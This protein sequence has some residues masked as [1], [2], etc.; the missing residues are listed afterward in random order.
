MF[1]LIPVYTVLCTVHSFLKEVQ[2]CT[3]TSSF[4]KAEKRRAE[5]DNLRS[6]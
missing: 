1:F 6:A 4:N 3:H 5:Y 2:T